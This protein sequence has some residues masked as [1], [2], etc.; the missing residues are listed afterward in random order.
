LAGCARPRRQHRTGPSACWI[1]A[2]EQRADYAPDRHGIGVRKRMDVRRLSL[3]LGVQGSRPIPKASTAARTGLAGADKCRIAKEFASSPSPRPTAERNDFQE[4]VEL[5]FLNTKER[6][7]AAFHLREE[8]GKG[9]AVAAGGVDQ[10]SYRLQIH[11]KG[12]VTAG[13]RAACMQIESKGDRMT[14]RPTPED[15]RNRISW[16]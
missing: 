5:D 15:W 8:A 2:S 4:P 7:D 6:A 16:R 14:A 12:S 11:R 1:T 3:D 10:E 13:R 9:N